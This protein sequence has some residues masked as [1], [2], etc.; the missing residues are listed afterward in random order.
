MLSLPSCSGAIAH[1]D[2]GHGISPPTRPPFHTQTLKSPQGPAAARSSCPGPHAFLGT[3]GASPV[4]GR[5]PSFRRFMSRV[6]RPGGR[7]WGPSRAPCT[8]SS[9]SGQ[10]SGGLVT[11][12][13]SSGSWRGLFPLQSRRS[14]ICDTEPSPLWLPSTPDT[15]LSGGLHPGRPWRGDVGPTQ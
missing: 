1:Q 7:D 8:Q 3:W 11:G 9:S 12:P 6:W 2:A 14:A 5:L 13:P 4:A 15:R 10:C